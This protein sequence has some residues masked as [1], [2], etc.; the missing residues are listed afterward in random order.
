MLELFPRAGVRGA[1]GLPRRP[2]SSAA[3]RRGSSRTS[4]SAT[5][6]RRR[7]AA[8]RRRRRR[9]R[10]AL[11]LLACR[12]RDDGRPEA[13]QAT[14]CYLTRSASA[15]W[16]STWADAGLPRRGRGRPGRDRARGRLPGQPRPHL[17]APFAG[18]PGRR[19]PARSPPLRPLH[20][21]RARGRRLD[22]R[23]GLAGALPLASRPP[24]L[25][26]SDQ[27]DAAG[28][29]GSPSRARRTRR[30]T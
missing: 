26:V 10:A 13:D 9:S 25:D 11:P 24:R 19:S 4:S 2:G 12:V 22:D 3:A 16:E 8:T 15:P 28:G 23:L 20:G 21:A 29:R 7:S 14:D 5:A 30:S 27:G 6:C 17:S 1:R 18:D